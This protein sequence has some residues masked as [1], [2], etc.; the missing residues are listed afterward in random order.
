MKKPILTLL[1]GI[2]VASG[3]TAQN[4]VAEKEITDLSKQK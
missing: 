3:V 1:I 4:S 2:L